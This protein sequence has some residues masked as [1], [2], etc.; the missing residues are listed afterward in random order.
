VEVSIG[1]VSNDEVEA[2]VRLFKALGDPT[3]LAVLMHIMRCGECS[4]QEIADAVNKSISLV[5]HHL[6]C[7]RNCG[8]VRARRE[9]KNI[10]YS[11]RDR[12]ILDLMRISIEHAKSYSSSINSCEILK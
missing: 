9:G 4:V 5:S 7:L 2:L 8:L 10:Y 3:R 11:V 12:H 6:S 1:E